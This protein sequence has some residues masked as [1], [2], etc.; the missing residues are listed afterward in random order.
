MHLRSSALHEKAAEFARQRLRVGNRDDFVGRVVENNEAVRTFLY[1]FVIETLLGGC[2]DGRPHLRIQKLAVNGCAHESDPVH[3]VAS[4]EQPERNNSPEGMPDDSGVLIKRAV[5]LGVVRLLLVAWLV[6][7]RQRRYLDFVSP[8][9]KLRLYPRPEIVLRRRFAAM[10]Q[11]KTLH[12]R[13]NVEGKVDFGT[14]TTAYPVFLGFFYFFRPIER[15]EVVDE[16]LRI[17][18]DFDIPLKHLLLHDLAVAPLTLTIYH[19]LVG[20]HGLVLGAPIYRRLFAVDQACF[21]KLQ[22]EPLR[23]F[24]VRG[25]AGDDLTRPI[26]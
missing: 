21:K 16:A 20:K 5:F 3:F 22:E 8:A 11:H 13:I 10:K 7:I 9:F 19:L 14:L 24:V 4:F 23:P 25:V 6:G 12:A 26:E 1:F 17:V 2:R 15:I 18:G